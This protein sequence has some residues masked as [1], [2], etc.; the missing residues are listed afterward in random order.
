M[1]ILT[2]YVF[3]KN[4]IYDKFR[5]IYQYNNWIKKNLRDFNIKKVRN[6]LY[7][8]IDS[9]GYN[10]SNKFQIASKINKYAYISY[11]SALEYYGLANQ[12][13]NDVIVSSSVRFNNFVFEDSEYIFVKSNNYEQVNF[14][15]LEE[16]RIPSLEKTIIDCI[17]DIN[18]AG[19]IEEIAN[20]LEQIKYLDEMKL[21]DAL[22]S[23][24]KVFL[25]QKTG[26]LLEMFNGNLSL[27]ENFFEEC[28]KH[29]TAQIKYFLNDD[30]NDVVLNKKWRLIAPINLT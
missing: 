4:D 1:R 5:N 30:Y 25:Y 19:G 24:N 7:V 10:L 27:S 29:L 8:S 21:L 20:A 16:I 28:K 15:E 18:L 14:I 3:N 26:Y 22:K 17:D 23:Y 6:S 9:K 2:P 11:H 12:V 13:F